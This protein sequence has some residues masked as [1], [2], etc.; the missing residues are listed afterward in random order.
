MAAVG[1]AAE[2]LDVA[3]LERQ[4]RKHGDAVIALLAIEGR[5]FVA[6]APEALERKGL[7]GALGFLQTEHVGAR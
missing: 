6:E 3:G 7:V 4:A 1:L 2:A 5:V